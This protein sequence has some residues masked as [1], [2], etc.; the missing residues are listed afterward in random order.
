MQ[1]YQALYARRAA[2]IATVSAAHLAALS[3]RM[4]D[5]RHQTRLESSEAFYRL[6]DGR[7]RYRLV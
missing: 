3:L 6:P 5:C 4:L 1:H 2:F 7:G